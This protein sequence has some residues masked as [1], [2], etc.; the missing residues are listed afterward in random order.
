MKRM[1]QTISLSI[2][3]VLFLA[4]ACICFGQQAVSIYPQPDSPLQLTNVVTKLRT[5]I[6]D[7]GQEWNMLT[8]EFVSR[9]VSDRTIRAY[10]IQQFQGESDEIV[11]MTQFSYA[12]SPSGFIK[13][14]Q[15]RNEE[16]GECG[17]T[18][19]PSNIKLAVDFVEFSDG[20]TWGKD[21][22]KSA[23]QLA[24]VRAAAKASLEYLK[25][26]NDQ[27]SIEAIIKALDKTKNFTPPENQSEIWKRGFRSGT[28]NT[29]YR[30]KRAYENE[31]IKGAK[32]ELQKSFDT[33]S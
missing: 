15:S 32:A 21:V 19:I 18:K 4:S 13:P 23:E 2:V 16:I 24:G 28:N 20:S 1:I 17:Y 25:R 26:I 10:T 14:N 8:V 3:F 12:A 31:G 11:G 30:I 6:D 9:N 5:S 33:S 29:K 22:S 27:N 7:K